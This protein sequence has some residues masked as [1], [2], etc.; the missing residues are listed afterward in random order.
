MENIPPVN[1]RKLNPFPNL[2]HKPSP[3]SLPAPLLSGRSARRLYVNYPF[4][5]LQTLKTNQ[6]VTMNFLERLRAIIEIDSI[7][8]PGYKA[9][10]YAKIHPPLAGGASHCCGRRT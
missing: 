9:R 6:V 5:C 7:L 2:G 8:R 1:V 10:S 4:R 3:V